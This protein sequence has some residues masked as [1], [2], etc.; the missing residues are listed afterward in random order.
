MA[1]AS[2]RVLRA[3]LP[4][5]AVDWTDPTSTHVLVERRVPSTAAGAPVSAVAA[6]GARVVLLVR[7]GTASVPAD[8]TLLQQDDRVHVIVPLASA[9]LL[10]R[11]LSGTAA[12]EVHG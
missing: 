9:E 8:T 12:E 11:M 6:V 5:S 7:S 2:R 3:V 10:D 4:G 1:W